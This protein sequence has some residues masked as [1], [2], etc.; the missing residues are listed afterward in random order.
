M[1][2]R[3]GAE[4]RLKRRRASFMVTGMWNRSL[5]VSRP[6]GA[7]TAAQ[8]R[9]CVVGQ[10]TDQFVCAGLAEKF[11]GHD[12]LGFRDGEDVGDVVFFQPHPDPACLA[13]ELIGGHP[14][15]RDTGLHSALK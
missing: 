10:F 6:V 12:H 15:E 14:S 9:P 8:T 11:H 3:M 13:V 1:R 4:M 7:V 2:W 5:T